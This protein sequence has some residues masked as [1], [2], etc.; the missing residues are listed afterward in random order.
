[1][2]DFAVAGVNTSFAARVYD[3]TNNKNKVRPSLYFISGSDGKEGGVILSRGKWIM[4]SAITGDKDRDDCEILSPAKIKESIS[5]WRG[6]LLK[7]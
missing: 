1:M 3:T 7:N 4:R 5:F 6:E 2:K